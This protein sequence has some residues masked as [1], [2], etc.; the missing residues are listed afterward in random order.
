MFYRQATGRV[1]LVQTQYRVLEAIRSQKVCGSGAVSLRGTVMS[2]LPNSLGS[3]LPRSSEYYVLYEMNLHRNVLF[4]MPWKK[5]RECSSGAMLVQYNFM[6]PQNNLPSILQLI[7]LA[8]QRLT[9]SKLQCIK[10]IKSLILTKEKR[11]NQQVTWSFPLSEWAVSEYSVHCDF[12][13]RTAGGNTFKFKLHVMLFIVSVAQVTGPVA[14]RPAM[15]N[16][17]QKAHTGNPSRW[18]LLGCKLHAGLI[19][20]EWIV[21]DQWSQRNPS[22]QKML[23]GQSHP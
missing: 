15:E 19:W 9:I 2:F 11:S 13:T 20:A 10:L 3:R 17:S 23:E 14:S 5:A 16:I 12:F 6:H 8:G 1:K 18:K 21:H 4:Y 7:I 22:Q